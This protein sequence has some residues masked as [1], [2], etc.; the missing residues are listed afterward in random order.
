MD[1]RDKAGEFLDSNCTYLYVTVPP[2]FHDGAFEGPEGMF[3]VE[4]EPQ[5]LT[6]EELACQNVFSGRVWELLCES[7]QTSCGQ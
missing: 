4:D 2:K 7:G 3:D 1:A 6:K 5:A